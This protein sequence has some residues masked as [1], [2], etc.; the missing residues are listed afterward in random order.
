M[1][2]AEDLR[3][4]NI[5]R[6]AVMP[7]DSAAAGRADPA[8]SRPG[9][10]Q[11]A[12]ALLTD[13]VYSSM[14]ALPHWQIVSEREVREVAA[15]VRDGTAQAR[16]I[17]ELVYADAVVV[18]RV[19]RFRQRVGED[20]GVQSPASVDFVLELVDVKRGDVVWRAEYQETQKALSENLLGLGDFTRRGGKWVRAEDLARDGAEKAVRQLNQMLYR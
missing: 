8:G 1:R 11:N 17:G 20:L 12:G 9:A 15:T 13:F 2:S 19:L 4:R 6:I 14:L 7:I 3:A 10:E 16:R 5:K 18:G